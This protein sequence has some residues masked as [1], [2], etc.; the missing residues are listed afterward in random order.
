M[1]PEPWQQVIKAGAQALGSQGQPGTLTARSLL[2][3]AQALLWDSGSLWLLCQV[4]IQEGRRRSSAHNQPIL[5]ARA[6]DPLTPRR[7]RRGWSGRSRTPPSL[8][9][10]NCDILP[11]HGT[12]QVLGVRDR[13]YRAQGGHATPGD[14]GNHENMRQLCWRQTAQ[15]PQARL[16]ARP[17]H[18][19]THPGP[20]PTEGAGAVALWGKPLPGTLAFYTGA[21]LSPGYSISDPGPCQCACK[22]SGG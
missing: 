2:S 21:S 6:Q 12:R 11:S 16:S 9:V 1:P 10:K 4:P 15:G 3:R 13:S 5:K 14:R 7:E 8:Q 22:G 18:T 17:A 20:T 19:H